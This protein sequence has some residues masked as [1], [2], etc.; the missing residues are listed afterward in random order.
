[1]R[2]SRNSRTSPERQSLGFLPLL[3]LILA[4]GW[5]C[6]GG[7]ISGR[8]QAEDGLALTSVLVIY[9]RRGAYPP[10][11]AFRDLGRVRPLPGREPFSRS[12][13]A[14]PD[15][16]FTI[17]NLADGEYAVCASAELPYL[18][19]CTWQPVLGAALKSGTDA[20]V[21]PTIILRRGA[22]IRVRLDA[23]GHQLA[24]SEDR[25]S[26]EFNIG[27]LTTNGRYAG[28]SAV[29]MSPVSKEWLVLVP[30][31]AV[32]RLMVG[33]RRFEV[34]LGAAPPGTSLVAETSLTSHVPFRLEKGETEREIPLRVVR[35]R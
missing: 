30:L 23:A 34:S 1:M 29:S 15:G 14:N 26:P 10:G 4:L 31:E 16:T 27:F 28:A 25:A 24:A 19:S 3:N 8:V 7:Q 33:A 32:G 18:S 2:R 9:S 22:V 21:L 17:P 5:P 6:S 11:T 13:R 35:R 12:L 20:V